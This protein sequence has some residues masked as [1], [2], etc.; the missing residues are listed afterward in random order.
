[1]AKMTFSETDNQKEIY[2]I[3]KMLMDV[4]PIT[5]NER[6][7]V[8]CSHPFT[9]FIYTPRMNNDKIDKT[10]DLTNPEDFEEWRT[11]ILQRLE[12][13]E[14]RN[15]FYITN[16][17]YRLTF[18]KYAQPYLTKQTFSELFG[19]IWV[20]SENPNDDANVS[21]RELVN[22]FLNADKK[23]LMDE[24]DY[25]AWETLPE[26]ME[27]Y[28]GVGISRKQYGLSWTTNLEK[29]TWFAHRFDREG[30]YGYVQKAIV[31]KKDMLA[32]FQSRE[33]EE[34]VVDTFKIKK[35]IEK[36]NN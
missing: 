8:F 6:I 7:P 13:S 4:V 10:W 5:P 31:S 15:M 22:W 20:T 26:T 14:I 25:A 3:A 23:S 27:L 34:V 16:K 2:N 28:R 21:L 9:D 32:Y 11:A 12:Q 19:D 36:V 29:A 24:K 18:L 17:A 33:E 35:M 30:Q 1:M